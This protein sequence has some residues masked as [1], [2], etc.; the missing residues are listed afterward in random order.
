MN[1]ENSLPQFSICILEEQTQLTLADLCG[2]CSVHD[3]QIIELVDAGVL[4]PQ[5]REPAH[6]IFAG[7]SLHRARCDWTHETQVSRGR[8]PDVSGGQGRR[9]PLRRDPEEVVLNPVD[10]GHRDLLG[11]ARHQL[12]IVVDGQ[13]APSDAL[14][15]GDRLDDQPGVVAEMAPGAGDES[16]PGLRFGTHAP[17][18]SGLPCALR[19][20]RPAKS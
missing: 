18:L 6:W 15:R 16:D 9:Q 12:G 20:V 1:T 19:Q 14:L 13:L 2:A 10:E 7:A 5:G 17:I 4:E 8:C 11:V 3:Q